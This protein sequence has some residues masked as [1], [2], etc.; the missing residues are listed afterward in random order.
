MKFQNMKPFENAFE[1]FFEQ[2]VELYI[3]K[4][5]GA[6]QIRKELMNWDEES[7]T[8]IVTE[9]GKRIKMTDIQEFEI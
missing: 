1:Y 4:M 6:E 9:L 8:Y 5:D 3:S 7:A 2:L